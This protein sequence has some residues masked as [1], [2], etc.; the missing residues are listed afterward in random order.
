MHGI[1]YTSCLP[2]LCLTR[3]RIII[4]ISFHFALRGI[5]WLSHHSFVTWAHTSP[6]ASG[7]V[8]NE[9]SVTD[10]QTG[11]VTS[12]NRGDSETATQTPIE[13]VR[14]SS[15]KYIQCVL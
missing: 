6:S 15:H 3:T 1:S 7:Q 4:S 5:E 14:V 12:L 2:F 11:K 13:T 10:I 9:I 8:R